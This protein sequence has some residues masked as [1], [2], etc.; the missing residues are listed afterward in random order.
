MNAVSIRNTIP[1]II[2]C[3]KNLRVSKVKILVKL[4]VTSTRANQAAE[5][6]PVTADSDFKSARRFAFVTRIV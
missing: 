6:F 2:F 3:V 5:R 1:K 4:G